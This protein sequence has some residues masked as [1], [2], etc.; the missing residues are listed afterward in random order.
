M[1]NYAPAP[2]FTKSNVFKFITN[3]TLLACM[4]VG[5]E[6]LAL[7]ML[8]QVVNGDVSISQSI[9][10]ELSSLQINQQTDKAIL[11]WNSFN[12]AAQEGV[13]FQQP[14]NGV[15]LNRIDAVNGMSQIQGALSATGKIYLINQAGILF[16]ES[17]KI[18]VG[19]I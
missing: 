17:A 10:S 4:C 8:D 13:H 12:I 18:N 16:S 14:L 1:Q 2:S 9:S 11:D 5:T 19:T 15:C 3:I 6:V 7:P